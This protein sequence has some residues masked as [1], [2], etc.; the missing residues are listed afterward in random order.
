[1]V[2]GYHQSGENGIATVTTCLHGVG[3]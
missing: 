3:G 2:V 1:V